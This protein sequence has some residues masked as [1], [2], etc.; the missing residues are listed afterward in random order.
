MEYVLVPV[1]ALGASLLTLFSGFGLGT[2]LLPAFAVFFPTPW[3]I[4]MT[5]VVHLLNNVFKLGLLARDADWRMVL[6]FG[7]PSVI[8][9]LLGAVLLER[10]QAVPAVAVYEAIGGRTA[11]VTWVGLVIGTLVAGFGVLELLPIGSRLALPARWMPVGGV[12]SGFFGGLSGHQGALRSA[13]LV[14][15]GLSPASLV[16]TRA[17]IAVMVDVTRI[18]VYA[19]AFSGPERAAVM[20]NWRLVALASVGAFVGAYVGSLLVR[21]VTLRALQVVVGVALVLFG[22]AMA[23]GLV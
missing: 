22:G 13:F 20:D 14:N 5:A 9:A 17:V 4:A 16:A 11:T 21:K 12:V 18:G 7:G 15:S 10:V 8:G 23:A 2:L 3:A 1:V 19:V 6:R